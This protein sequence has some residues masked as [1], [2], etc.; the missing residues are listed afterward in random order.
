MTYHHPSTLARAALVLFVLAIGLAAVV[1]WPA[2]P[3]R[4]QEPT[5]SDNQ[6]NAV[7]KQ[8]YC[9]VCEN[10]PLDVCPTQACAQWRQTIR[11]KLTAGWSEQEIKNYFVE[12]YGA[13]VLAAPPPRGLSLLVYLL[14]PLAFVVGGYIV[15]RAVRTWRRAARPRASPP[16][17]AEDEYARRIE[18]ELRRRE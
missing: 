4:A 15:Y 5:P 17:A 7:A 2:S 1:S 13:R 9:P 12:Q 10:V 3:A 16:P 18:E 8:L 14:P 11:E 6:V